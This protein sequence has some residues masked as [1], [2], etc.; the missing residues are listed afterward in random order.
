MNRSAR[1]VISGSAIVLRGN[2][3]DT[4]R[5]MPARFLRAI[6]FDGLEAHIFEDDRTSLR[7]DGATH[8]FDDPARRHAR[9]LMVDANFGCGS[10]RE[11]APQAIVRWGIQ[12]VVGES[13]AEIFFG[14]AVAIGLPCVTAARAELTPLIDAAARDAAAAFTVDLTARTVTGAGLTATGRIPDSARNALITGQWDAT[15][16]LLERYDEVER[17]VATLPYARAFK[18]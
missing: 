3:I 15:S 5:V 2:D 9:I 8:P 14:N 12:A 7:E 16:L 4:D 18:E 13:F 17:L 6:T 1:T 10:S 11:H